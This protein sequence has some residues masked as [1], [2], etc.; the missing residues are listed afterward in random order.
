MILSTGRLI[1]KKGH[2]YL[3]EACRILEESGFSNFLCKIIGDGPLKDE[4]CLLVSRLELGEKILLLGSL[5]QD[6]VFKNLKKADLFVLPCI[7]ARN[8]DMDGIPVSLMEAMACGKPVI[9]T[10]ISG[11]PELVKEGAGVLVPPGDSKAIADAIREVICLDHKERAYMGRK[12]R[13]IVLRE[14]DLRKN[15][16][17]IKSLLLS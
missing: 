6:E 10:N 9:S 12:G 17:Q 4:L 2:R 8:G 15:V 16:E 5:S 7:A 14:F 3:I 11:I 1:E 13:E